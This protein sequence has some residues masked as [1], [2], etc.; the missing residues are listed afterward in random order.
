VSKL[1][2]RAC[3]LFFQAGASGP[4]RAKRKLL[5]AA[6]RLKKERRLAARAG[7]RG[8]ISPECS[9]ALVERIVETEERARQLALVL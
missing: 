3:G 5:E 6:G 9:A 4:R 1:S 7:K 8:V 2:R